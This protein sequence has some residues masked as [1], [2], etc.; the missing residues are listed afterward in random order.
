MTSNTTTPA[1]STP[2]ETVELGRLL[3]AVDVQPGQ[4]VY[5]HDV[6]RHSPDWF[7]VTR[8]TRLRSGNIRLDL[9]RADTSTFAWRLLPDHTLRVLDHR[10]PPQTPQSDLARTVLTQTFPGHPF[11]VRARSGTTHTRWTDGPAVSRVAATLARAG[12]RY[13]ACERTIAPAT[14]AAIIVRLW[15]DGCVHSSEGSAYRRLTDNLDQLTD[16]DH[17]LGR[18][19]L[20]FTGDAD[21]M[22]LYHTLCRVGLTILADTA[23]VTIPV[24]VPV[25]RPC[26]RP[27]QFSAREDGTS[28]IHYVCERCVPQHD[29]VSYEIA[30]IA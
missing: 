4:N 2:S 26:G 12:V 25:C 11:A 10:P 1:P 22:A 29:F 3:T 19:L 7:T 27:A 6:R 23:N 15:R 20:A 8:S 24:S 18:Q 21:W 17:Q 30:P 14:H 9:A 16:I 13:P 5:L 28:E